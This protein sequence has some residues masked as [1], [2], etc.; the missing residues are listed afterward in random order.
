MSLTY[1][2]VHEPLQSRRSYIVRDG[3]LVVGWLHHDAS[4]WW[5]ELSDVKEKQ[6]PFWTWETAQN[7]LRK[8]LRG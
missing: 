2:L 6:G 8:A 3:T 7:A 1:R 5:V 4:G